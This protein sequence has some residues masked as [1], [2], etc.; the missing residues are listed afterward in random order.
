MGIHRFPNWLVAQASCP[1]QDGFT[2]VNL[3]GQRT[4]SSARLGPLACSSRQAVR[5]YNG[6]SCWLLGAHASLGAVVRHPAE[7]IVRGTMPRT[8]RWKRALPPIT[9]SFCIPTVAHGPLRAARRRRVQPPG[10][11]PLDAATRPGDDGKR[12]VAFAL[13]A[14]LLRPTF[15]Y[16]TPRCSQTGP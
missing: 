8:T 1:P 5:P 7:H 13:T 9:P 6:A 3:W 2:V 12:R 14:S 4:S 10:T 15:L 16:A 11:L